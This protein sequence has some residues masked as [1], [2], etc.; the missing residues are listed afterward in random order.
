AAIR[1]SRK[2]GTPSADFDPNDI[3]RTAEW[4]DQN[5]KTLAKDFDN[6]IR[7][8]EALK[9]FHKDM[10]AHSGKQVRW[11]FKV[12]RVSATGVDLVPLPSFS[13]LQVW[14]W[15]RLLDSDKVDKKNRLSPYLVLPVGQ[16]IKRDQAARLRAGDQL[17]VNAEVT[18]IGVDLDLDIEPSQR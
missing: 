9:R 18:G 16:G 10:Q 14:V 13:R 4:A 7:L 11:P 2:A 17:M 1:K 3:K 8:D 15:G 6:A 12:A 5:I